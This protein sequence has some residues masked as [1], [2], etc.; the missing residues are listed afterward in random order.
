M[1]FT[2]DVYNVIAMRKLRE[3]NG[4]ANRGLYSGMYAADY[5]INYYGNDVLSVGWNHAYS[6]S[7]IIIII[8]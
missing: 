1:G 2:S 7:I 8:M 5:N 4:S 6:G 3:E